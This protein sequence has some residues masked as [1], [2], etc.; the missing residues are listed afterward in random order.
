MQWIGEF[1]AVQRTELRELEEMKKL[2]ISLNG[3][4]DVIGKTNEQVRVMVSQMD[5]KLQKVLEDKSEVL[6]FKPLSCPGY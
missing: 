5:E 1:S 3:N 4:L 2:M 6:L